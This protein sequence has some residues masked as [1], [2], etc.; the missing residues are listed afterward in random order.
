MKPEKY[1][2]CWSARQNA[3]HVESEAESFRINQEAFREG[4]KVDYVPI[5][6]F[7]SFEA[8]DEAADSLRHVLRER[9]AERCLATVSE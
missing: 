4:R 5:G 3:F 7:S 2:L 8:A 6:H 1:W 9:D